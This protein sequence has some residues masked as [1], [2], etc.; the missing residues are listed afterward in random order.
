MEIASNLTAPVA[1]FAA[2]YHKDISRLKRYSFNHILIDTGTAH[3][4]QTEEANFDIIWRSPK[5]KLLLGIEAECIG[6]LLD[7]C[8]IF[9]TLRAS[10]K[11]FV[12]LLKIGHWGILT[13]A[14]TLCGVPA[15]KRAAIAIKVTK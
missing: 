9:D 15:E 5:R 7:V 6:V 4:K 2:H 11:P 12:L 13:S 14:L 10:K 3:Y 1:S 8:S